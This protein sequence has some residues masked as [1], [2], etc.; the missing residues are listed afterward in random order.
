MSRKRKTNKTFII[1]TTLVVLFLV[2]IA[3]ILI[4]LVIDSKWDGKSRFSII[5]DSDPL[6]LFSTQPE[7]SSATF[8]MIP[9]NTILDVPFGYDNYVA[10]SIFK[11]GNLDKKRSG[12]LLL[13]KSIENTFG[14]LTDGFIAQKS[15]EKFVFMKDVSDLSRVKKAYFS[16]GAVLSNFYKIPFMANYI[17]T[18]ISPFD[19]IK[20]WVVVR[21]LR[22]DQINIIDLS[23][24]QVLRSENLEDNTQVKPVDEDLFDQ[25]YKTDF[26]DQKIRM[27]DASIEVV[28][29]SDR[30]GIA[31]QF[32]RI[33]EHLGVNVVAKN[34]INL[35]ENRFSCLIE[36]KN[37]ELFSSIIVSKVAGH[38]KCTKKIA[39]ENGIA[40]IKIILGEDFL[41]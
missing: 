41:R 10:Q 25:I 15:G 14:I 4:K 19:L 13:T 30:D 38:F 3:F 6:I 5:L 20:F 29:T 39:T 2:G 37:K 22:V 36:V 21:N 27:Q 33:L 17:S 32:G 16:L 26:H 1:S 9:A 35:A 40:D 7:N 23:Q 12:G 28:N 8:L 24:S 34:S 11:L 18:N 31:T